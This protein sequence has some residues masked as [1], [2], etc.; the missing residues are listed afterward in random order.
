MGHLSDR[1]VG[2]GTC[3]LKGPLSK[4][5]QLKLLWRLL[6]FA[7][8]LLVLVAPLLMLSSSLLQ[9]LLGVG[10]LTGL[11]IFWS[12]RV[13]GKS[14][15]QYGLEASVPMAT[16]LAIGLIIGV[17][18]VGL[19][20][21]LVASPA[22]L[23]SLSFQN[24]A[25]DAAFGLFFLKTMLVAFWE[26][27]MFRGFLLVNLRNSFSVFFGTTRGMMV[28]IFLSSLLFGAIHSGTEHFTWLAF[29]ILTLNGII[30]C[31]PMILTGR[32]ALSIG[33]HASWNFAQSKIFG[34]AMSGNASDGAL[35]DGQPTGSDFWTGGSYG[36]EGG[37]VGVIGLMAM[38]VLIMGYACWTK[39]LP[40]PSSRS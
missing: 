1:T 37:L 35:L 4:I 32:L 13:D 12:D 28:A 10:L 38:L 20:F 15:R 33:L 36:P 18:C 29:A 23:N 26:E 8:L 39:K 31:V 27:T 21:L 17:L 30:W 14:I 7:T 24:E 9:F 16:E 3:R 19:M 2:I 40:M 22:G 5:G 6:I 11:L 34:F 25:F